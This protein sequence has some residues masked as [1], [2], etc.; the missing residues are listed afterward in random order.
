M[1]TKMLLGLR[2]YSTLIQTPASSLFGLPL[3]ELMLHQPHL[4]QPKPRAR[5]PEAQDR[6]QPLQS[7]SSCIFSLFK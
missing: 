7:T 5:L 2:T 4:P 1:K 6:K 3:S